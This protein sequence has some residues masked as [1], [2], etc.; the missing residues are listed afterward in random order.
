MDINLNKSEMVISAKLVKSFFDDPIEKIVQCTNDLLDNVS[1]VD[2]IVLVGGFS[3]SKYLQSVM[4][5]TFGN[6]IIKPSHQSSA[7][8]KGAVMYG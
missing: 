8:Q 4:L 2:N 7:V 6:K 3:E 5:S 1:D